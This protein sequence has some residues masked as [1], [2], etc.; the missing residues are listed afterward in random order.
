MNSNHCASGPL[1]LVQSL[2]LL[3]K[4]RIVLFIPRGSSCCCKKFGQS[5][6]SSELSDQSGVS[7][8]MGDVKPCCWGMM[9]IWKCQ[10]LNQRSP[11]ERHA[12]KSSSPQFHGSLEVQDHA[13]IIKLHRTMKR[14][15]Y[16]SDEEIF[17]FSGT[18][19]LTIINVE[20]K[21]IAFSN[22]RIGFLSRVQFSKAMKYL[23]FNFGWFSSNLQRCYRNN[24]R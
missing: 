7:R 18:I 11:T 19:I 15:I 14:L 10:G 23:G 20:G 24:L 6:A 5:E 13:Y 2:Y 12:R 4:L 9:K 3:C 16:F 1:V 8:R 21:C 22:C 17:I